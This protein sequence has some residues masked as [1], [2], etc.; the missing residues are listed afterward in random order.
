MARR[1]VS[2][3]N[4]SVRMFESDFLEHFS[5]VHPATPLVVFVPVLA[6][7]VYL[8]VYDRHLEFGAILLWFI[9]G[10]LI[11]TF[12][13][14][15]LHRFVFHYEPKTVWGK[16]LH[17]LMHGVHHDYPSDAT[18]LVMPPGFSI[19]LAIIF[20]ILTTLV[21]GARLTPPIFSGMVVGYLC[22]DMLHY[23]TH[24][25]A[26]KRGVLLALKQYHMR[27]H[28]GDE[29]TGY[30]VSSPIWDYVFGTAQKKVK[31]EQEAMQK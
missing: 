31:R 28:Y 5:H 1:Y 24:H 29:D 12:L 16:R 10:M 18:R 4:E 11:W 17:F 20:Y 3:R 13:E 15:M 14:Y 8:S 27:H 25:F 23:A 26:M 7:M 21:F 6:Y 19:P 9:V 22:Y 30:G 2:N